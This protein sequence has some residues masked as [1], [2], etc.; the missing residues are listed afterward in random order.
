MFSLCSHG[1]KRS[2][3][4]SSAARTVKKLNEDCF[5]VQDADADGVSI[6]FIYSRDDLHR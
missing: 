4:P 5:T 3:T 2:Q 6:T 1:V